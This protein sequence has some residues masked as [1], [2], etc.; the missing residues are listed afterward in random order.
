MHELGLFLIH[1]C[2]GEIIKVHPRFEGLTRLG[3]AGYDK[4]TANLGYTK[5]TYTKATDCRTAIL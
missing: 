4:S 5:H 1:L 3:F 2:F